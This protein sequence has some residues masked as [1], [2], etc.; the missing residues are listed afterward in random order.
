MALKRLL[1]ISPLFFVNAPQPARFRELVSRWVAHF[2]VT[3]LAFNTGRNDMFTQTVAD[4]S[5]MEFS[6]AGR[7]L[8]GSRLRG[9]DRQQQVLQ[10]D[11]F[12][13]RS[14]LS[15][16]LPDGT[17]KRINFR[18]LLRKIHINRFFFPDIFI[19][20]YL[21]IKRQVM[22]LS[23]RIQPDTVI[24]SMAPFTLMLLSG[25]LK[26]RFPQMKIVIDTGDPFYGDSSSYSG[27]LMHRL[28]ARRVEGRG[29]AS[30]DL[31]VVPT[32]ILKKHY[33]ACYGSVIAENR[34]RVVENGISEVFTRI[35]DGRAD[36][37]APFRMVYAGRF[38]K[39]MRD[40]S[41]LYTAVQ[42]FS[43]GEVILK[44][45][46]NI[47][48][49]YLPPASDPRFITGGAVSAGELARE[50]GQADLVIYL[51]N[52]YGVQVPGKVYEVLAVNRP[53]LYICRD[54]GSPSYE[55]VSGQD[56]IVTVLNDHR[57][58][59]A[60][61][62]QVMKQSPGV[63]Y[64]RGSD[65]YTFDSLAAGYRALLEELNARGSGT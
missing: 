48:E 25:P 9:S 39:K 26:R 16:L 4:M 37:S 21:N 38:Y 60:G 44:V 6:T 11:G 56:G 32:V 18:G 10:A 2:E 17:R 29:L 7:L 54:T 13:D 52:A 19:V 14:N 53:V 30:A 57:D 51:D 64:S 46:G 28:F 33:L 23:E 65:R 59:A 40:P 49:K 8:I 3:I 58:I 41:A 62:A 1:V 50:Y 42:L 61:I 34:I 36:R 12:R 35:S 5:L 24:I 45:F 27:R 31:L 15:G 22:T 20:E 47:Q 55:L 63:K 43:A